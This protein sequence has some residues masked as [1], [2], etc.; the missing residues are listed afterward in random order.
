MF[1]RILSLSFLV[2]DIISSAPDR[3]NLITVA[4]TTR[5]LERNA[6]KNRALF[7]ISD[8]LLICSQYMGASFETK[9]IFYSKSNRAPEVI[10]QYAD[11]IS[12]RNFNPLLPTK[13]VTH[14]YSFP[15]SQIAYSE[16]IMEI[17]NAYLDYH[18]VN[19]IVV[20]W[21]AGSNHFDYCIPRRRVS[22][23]GKALAKL[24]DRL[25]GSSDQRLWD[26]LTLVGHSLG[27]HASGDDAEVSKISQT[28]IIL[29]SKDSPVEMCSKAES[30]RFSGSTQRVLDLIIIQLT[31]VSIRTM[32]NTLKS[33]TRTGDVSD[34]RSQSVTQV[35][36]E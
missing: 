22:V 8:V 6:I 35:F 33:F 13:V 12:V 32:Q 15:S 23:V 7:C 10:S 4:N 26:Q 1:S 25:L 17:V 24:L 16:P 31:I 20:D 34:S 28:L 11:P 9:F 29:F 14:G 3:S 30:E 5:V 2:V 27:A 19:V 36:Q 21:G 18:N